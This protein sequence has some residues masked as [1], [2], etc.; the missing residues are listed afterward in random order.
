MSTQPISYSRTHSVGLLA[1]FKVKLS[2]LR[3]EWQ[4]A[5]LQ[6]QEIARITQELSSCSD[7]QLADLG[8]SRYDIADVARG[9]FG[10]A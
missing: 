7:R 6:R 10:R 4:Q 3:L 5:T 1:A 9:T 8:F 2:E